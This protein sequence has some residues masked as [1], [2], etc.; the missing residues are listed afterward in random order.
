MR[1]ALR[2]FS[3]GGL[4]FAVSFLVAACGGDSRLLTGA[5]SSS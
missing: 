2:A 1:T 3:A 4:G 5:E